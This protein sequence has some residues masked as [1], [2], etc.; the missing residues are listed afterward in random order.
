MNETSTGWSS[1]VT[2]RARISP[3]ALACLKPCPEQPPASTMR[4]SPGVRPTT[5]C[6][7]GLSV[8]KHGAASYGSSTSPGTAQPTMSAAAR[9]STDGRIERESR[10]GCTAI[11]EIGSFD[12]PSFT[13]MSPMLPCPQIVCSS[14]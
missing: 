9:Q 2:M 6:R 10:S 1:S 11:F 14:S 7:S 8:I 3:M 5:N 13:G 4:S 12:S